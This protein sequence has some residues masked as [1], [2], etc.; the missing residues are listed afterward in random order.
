MGRGRPRTG[1]ALRNGSGT[2]L[3]GG[4][5]DACAQ[6]VALATVYKYS[7]IGGDRQCSCLSVAG[8][9]TPSSAG[10]IWQV[11]FFFFFLRLLSLPRLG[12]RHVH[13]WA[14]ETATETPISAAWL[15]ARLTQRSRKST[16]HQL[17]VGDGATQCTHCCKYTD[18]GVG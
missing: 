12:V 5:A 2:H 9:I 18:P 6:R 14:S 11:F 1:Q 8:P 17:G 4:A 7:G 10:S 15:A 13:S 3:E 16:R